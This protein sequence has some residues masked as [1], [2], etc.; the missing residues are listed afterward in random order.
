MP[1]NATS[2]VSRKYV[3]KTQKL[4]ILKTHG[5]FVEMGEVKTRIAFRAYSSAEK[6]CRLVLRNS[7]GSYRTPR[8]RAHM[9][10]VQSVH[11]QLLHKQ[12]SKMQG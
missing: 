9:A 10:D 4:R 8:P 1:P 12:L 3:R 7:A 5:F 6:I 11:P 2:D